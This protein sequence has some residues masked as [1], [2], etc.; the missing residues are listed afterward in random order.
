MQQ[1]TPF[2]CYFLTRIKGNYTSGQR[3]DLIQ[4]ATIAYQ[5]TISDRFISKTIENKALTAIK[6]YDHYHQLYPR[7]LPLLIVGTHSVLVGE[8]TG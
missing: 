2:S 5:Q 3:F 4:I 1:I 7:R 6:K 8:Q